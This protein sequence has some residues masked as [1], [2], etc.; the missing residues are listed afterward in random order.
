MNLESSKNIPK[1][2]EI[3]FYLVNS[4]NTGEIYT[5]MEQA[6]SYSND[7]GIIYKEMQTIV[8]KY[9]VALKNL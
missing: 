4:S 3:R 8:D 1:E 5:T 2:S 7:K 9:N 6:A